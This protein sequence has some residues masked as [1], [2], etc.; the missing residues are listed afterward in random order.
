[1]SNPAPRA[2]R[3]ETFV[4]ARPRDLR[5]PRIDDTSWSP[6]LAEVI[7]ERD[8]LKQQL[9]H[10]RDLSDR[11]IDIA[12]A[13]QARIVV[14]ENE[15]KAKEEMLQAKDEMI[16]ALESENAELIKHV[17]TRENRISE[18]ERF[19]AMIEEADSRG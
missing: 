10:V 15:L 11:V 6:V 3:D 13:Q 9:D 4:N 18:L 8:E 19:M 7:A 16:Q 17:S 14:L 5:W 2:E 12:D 1:M